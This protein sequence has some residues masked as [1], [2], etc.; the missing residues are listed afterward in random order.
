MIHYLSR[1]QT[2]VR[3]NWYSRSLCDCS[4]DSMTF[5][6]MATQMEKLHIL[7]S[8]LKIKQGDK[9]AICARN[10]ANWGVAFLAVN[11][12]GAVVVPIL[13]DFHTDSIQGI[14]NHSESVM[15]FADSDIYNKLDADA[16][17]LVETVLDVRDF[18]ALKMAGNCGE[19]M[20]SID[21]EF[22]R[23]YPSGFRPDDVVYPVDNDHELAVINYTSG[24]TGQP[25]GV[26]IR[27]ECFSANIDFAHKRIPSYP[28]DSILSIL[29]MAHM[30]GMVFELLYPLCGGSSVYYLGKAPSPALLMKAMAKVRPF[31]VIAVPM[32]FE[33]IYKNKILPEIRKPLVRLLAAIPLARNLVYGKIRKSIDESFGG[34][35]RMYIMGGA[36][37]N[38]EV[39][40]FLKKI[41]LHFTVGY[42]M[43]EAAPLIAYEDWDK[44]R[45][46]S[47]GKAMDYVQLRVD[48][49][50]PEKVAGE[51]Q[52]RGTN[53]CSGYFRNE[54]ATAAAFTEDGWFNTGDLGVIDASG[55]VFIKG[56][57]KSMLLTSNGQN[58]YPEEIES[59]VNSQE[60]A[61]E[62]VVVMRDDKLVA[63]VQL[64]QDAISRLGLDKQAV[65]GLVETIRNSA[66]RH[67][68]KY[69]QISKIE[70]VTVPF[71]KTPKM[72]IKRYL[73]K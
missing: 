40:A 5:G 13:A 25:K 30:F 64:D 50:D 60:F 17:P 1:L 59:I 39:E 37:V 33:K 7:F 19:I 47:C 10:R 66:N 29:P 45:L 57:S 55:N 41:K 36:A 53:I 6:Q 65:D 51:I 34:N 43:T 54:A 32:V 58:I 56:R 14:L 52:A 61:S 72:S 9:I 67:L 16:V 11:T 69:S 24:S 73:Y 21:S 48:S 3:N 63:L 8:L 23:M 26:M 49:S 18:H 62:S 38:P 2:Q 28:A 31:L 42:G 46:R 71:E 68:S 27:Y 35:V 44:F 20:D 22:N 15:L 12:Y 4:G 70:V